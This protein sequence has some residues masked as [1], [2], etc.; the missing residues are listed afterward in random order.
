[1]EALSKIETIKDEIKAIKK[2]VEEVGSSS[3]DQD[4]EDK[5]KS[6]KPPIFKGALHAEE[7]ENFLC[8]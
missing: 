3:L 6:S 4:N 7:V 8:N 5:V 2:G 1:M